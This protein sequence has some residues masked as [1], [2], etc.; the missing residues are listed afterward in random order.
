MK[1][2]IILLGILLTFCSP[3]QSAFVHPGV[4]H[5]QAE[6][7]FVRQKIEAGEQPWKD[8]YQELKR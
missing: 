7:D 5:S 2:H 1:N 4:A 3:V 6:L 8:A